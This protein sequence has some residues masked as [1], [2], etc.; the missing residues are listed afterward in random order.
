MKGV[1]N[2]KKWAIV[3]VLVIVLLIIASVAM[4]LVIENKMNVALAQAVVETAIGKN[5]SI[6]ASYKSLAYGEEE[7]RMFDA[8]AHDNGRYEF[9]SGRLENSFLFNYGN[10]AM[11][12]PLLG[13]V[14]RFRYGSKGVSVTMTYQLLGP[15][16]TTILNGGD[17]S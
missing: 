6:R 16:T 4:R 17:P 2:V 5:V 11:V 13:Q 1:L 9:D 15:I 7:T 8:S 14:T 3:S 10:W 12:G